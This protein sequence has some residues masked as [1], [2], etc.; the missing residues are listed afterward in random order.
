MSSSAR[1]SRI[2]P[3]DT[4]RD[5][6]RSLV[7]GALVFRWVWLVWMA[8]LA[9]MGHDELQREWLAW[10]SIAAATAWTLWLTSARSS[11]NSVVLAFDVALGIWLIGVSA[12]VV[13]EG[14]IIS[15]RPF[16]ATGYPLSA[17]LL[18][19]AMRGPVA[20]AVTAAALAI[21]HLLS[22]PLN[23]IA[24]SDLSPAQVQNVTGVMLNYFVG[25]IA[26]GLVA[27][28]LQRS[29]AAVRAANET[30]I[31]ERELSARLGERESLARAIHD[32][33]LQALALVH[34]R[35][36]ELAASSIIDPHEV[37]ALADI[38]GKQQ[39]ELR[40]LILRMP[41]AAPT[42]LAALR[43]AV[44]EEARAVDGITIEVS[45]TG[46]YWLPRALVGEL[47]AAVRQ[48]LE[49][50]ARHSGA[51]RATVFVEEEA[52]HVVAT[53]RD[54]GSGFA[55]DEA[56]LAA[57]GKVGILKSMKGRVEDLGG[58]M[59]VT[60]QPGQGTEIEFRVPIPDA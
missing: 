32:S 38:A 16:F 3:L 11:W 50:A 59:L 14:E 51:G 54:N 35:G 29:A 52:G 27:R 1:G 13:G 55:Y 5:E 6:S 28:L 53:V 39:E 58:S 31:K 47:R 46:A 49:N 48:A 20:G 15:G 30:A 45:A 34:K 10:G 23:G 42:G 44:E 57:Q 37:T 26:V 60:T 12:F 9:A 17:P 36:K 8:G 21:A 19:G 7:T 4:V 41:E 43:D 2:R 25:G 18:W 33:V 24:L 22:R 56:A 40:A